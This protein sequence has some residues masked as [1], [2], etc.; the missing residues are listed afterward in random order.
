MQ[1][2]ITLLGYFGVAD[3]TL[4]GLY[5]VLEAFGHGGNTAMRAASVS[6]AEALAGPH[7]IWISCECVRV[8]VRG[9]GRSNS[10]VVLLAGFARK[11]LKLDWDVLVRICEWGKGKNNAVFGSQVFS[12]TFLCPLLDH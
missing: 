3:A 12:V 6:C 4:S 1:L 10:T 8:C 2:L 9:D 5:P 11:H 7:D